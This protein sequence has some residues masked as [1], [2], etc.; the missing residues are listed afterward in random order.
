MRLLNKKGN[1]NTI[2]KIA[3]DEKTTVLGVVG[4]VRDMLLEHLFDFCDDNPD[5]WACV[6]TDYKAFFGDSRDEAIAAAGIR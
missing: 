3:N 5:R 4:T 2:R 1:E 6:R